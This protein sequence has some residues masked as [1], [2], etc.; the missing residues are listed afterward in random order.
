M[1][2]MEIPEKLPLPWEDKENMEQKDDII[3]VLKA[4][5]E[6]LDGIWTELRYL[7]GKD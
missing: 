7:N 2:N 5:S 3:D 6:S 1:S 4:I